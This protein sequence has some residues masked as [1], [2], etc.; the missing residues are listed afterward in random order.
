MSVA[1]TGKDDRNCGYTN[2]RPDAPGDLPARRLGRH[3]GRRRR[4]QHFNAA[5]L[6]PAALQ[7]GDHRLRARRQRRPPGRPRRQGVLLV[8]QLRQRRHVR[9]TS[10]TTARDVDLIAPGKCILVDPAR[11]P[12]RLPLGHVDGRAA[13]DRAPPPCTRPP[14]PTATPEPGQARAP[15][16]RQ[17]T[18]GRRRPTPT[19]RTSR[20]STSRTSSLLGDFAM[21]AR[22]SPSH[23]LRCVGRHGQRSASRRSAP[24]TSRDPISL[25][26][27]A[28]SPLG[29]LAVRHRSS[30][31]SATATSQARPI[32]VPPAAPARAPTS[33][34]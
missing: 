28:D 16:V 8:G 19:G 34:T 6:V 12:L 11:Q 23:G 30:R 1:K 24:R 5:R 29:G 25:S 9:R 4:Q 10:R 22:P 7:R 21:D 15:R 26:V 31:A 13:R 33:S 27:D 14:G 20:C 32:T 18:T 2:K 3:R 17:R